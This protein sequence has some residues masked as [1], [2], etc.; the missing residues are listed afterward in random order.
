VRDDF[1]A[2]GGHSLLAVRLFARVH[3]E[4]KVDLPLAVLFEAPTIERLAERNASILDAKDRF[5][6]VLFVGGGNVALHQTAIGL[7]A[8]VRALR[9]LSLSRTGR[10]QESV[11]E[12]REIMAAIDANDAARAE[13]ACTRHVANAGAVVAEA[14]SALG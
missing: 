13:L 11:Q 9:S 10:A 3:Q 14:L 2:S 6:D 12:L 8:R 5:Y 4:L 1:F 7:H